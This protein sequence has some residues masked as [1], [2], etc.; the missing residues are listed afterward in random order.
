[1]WT[2]KL[3]MV[4]LL[5]NGKFEF[6]PKE[7]ASRAQAAAFISRMLTVIE[8]APDVEKPPVNEEPK[9]K[10]PKTPEEPKQEVDTYKVAIIDGNKK[11]VPGSESYKTYADAKKAATK[12]NQVVTFNDKIISMSSGLVIIQSFCW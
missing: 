1:M 8:K 3:S 11:L 6:R 5:E 4:F 9:A 7:T 12:S 2:M 10:E